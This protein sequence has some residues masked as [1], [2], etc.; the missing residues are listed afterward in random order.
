MSKRGAR[1]SA[2]A[3]PGQ[4]NADPE[5]QPKAIQQESDAHLAAPGSKTGMSIKWLR[6]GRLKIPCGFRLGLSLSG[7]FGPGGKPKLSRQ[8]DPN[9]KVWDSE[10]GTFR[11]SQ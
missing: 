11:N 2:N 4:F 9:E 5:S 7:K 8:P 3:K 1:N 6:L 10:T